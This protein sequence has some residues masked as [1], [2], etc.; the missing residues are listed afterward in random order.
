MG[1][2]KQAAA[3]TNQA[4]VQAG[5]GDVA[6]TMQALL[7]SQ[8]NVGRSMNQVLARADEQQKFY[9]TF[10]SDLTNKIAQ[11]R[12]EIALVKSLQKRAEWLRGLKI[13]M[14]TFQMQQ[15]EE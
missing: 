14:L 11:R 6:G 1:Y 15:Q 2:L 10:T 5:G 12:M 3:G 9:N 7:G 13:L 4:I 8:A